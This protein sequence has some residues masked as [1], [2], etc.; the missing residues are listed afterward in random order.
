MSTMGKITNTVLAYA[1]F[2]ATG[3]VIVAALYMVVVKPEMLV[4]WI[5]HST[6]ESSGDLLTFAF[7]SIKRF[8]IYNPVAYL[9]LGGFLL[10]EKFLPARPEQKILSAS[11]AQD[12]VWFILQRF[13]DGIVIATYVS[14]LAS[15]YNNYLSFLSAPWLRSL[16]EGVVFAWAVL[17]GDFFQWF[18]HWVRHKVPVLWQFHTVHH[19]QKE[20]SPFT[21][22]RYHIVEYIVTSTIQTIPMLILTVQN[23]Y[24]ILYNVSISWFTRFYHGNIKTNLGPL[25]YVL[26]T[27][28]SHRI[29]HS[30]ERRHQDKNFGLLFSIWDRLFG[31]QYEGYDEYPETGIEDS[32]FPH[33]T[34]TK[35]LKLFWTP[36]AQHLYPFKIIARTWLRRKT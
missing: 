3:L 12:V 21:D 24:I 2:V 17:V 18:H 6:Q 10:L 1:I 36:I 28:Q 26:V 32:N 13:L 7:D 14:V 11:F 9:L 33:E 27:P 29:H 19:S 15:L 31:T 20:L 22:Q 35:G 4:A 30:I 8:F 23:P 25:R 34:S 5:S 16:P